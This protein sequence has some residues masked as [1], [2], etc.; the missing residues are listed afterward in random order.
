MAEK[1]MFDHGNKLDLFEL[2]DE[3]DGTKRLVD[4]LPLYDIGKNERVIIV[5]ELD[6]SLHSK[7][8]QKYIELFFKITADKPSQLICTTHDVNLINLELLRQDE[9]WFV[10]RGKDHAS[11]IYSLSDYLHRSDKNVMNDYLLGRYG[12]IPHIDDI[13]FQ[14]EMK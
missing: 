14:E 2:S 7:L 10:E 6:R 12:A 3:S 8:T 9:I 1:I 11:R 4:L 5:D 13:E